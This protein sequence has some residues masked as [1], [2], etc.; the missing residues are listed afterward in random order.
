M[1]QSTT[2]DVPKGGDEENFLM[3]KKEFEMY[4]KPEETDCVLKTISIVLN[5]GN[6]IF[7]KG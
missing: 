3:I 1:N 6:L 2:Y 7:Q 5:V 4:L